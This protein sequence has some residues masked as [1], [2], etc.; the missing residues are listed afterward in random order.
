MKTPKHVILQIGA[1]V[2]LYVSIV[3]LLILIFSSINLTFPNAS[4][5]L[6]EDNSARTAI[7]TSIAMLLVFFPA[8][9]MF[10]RLSN[11]ERRKYLHGKYTLIT[12][13]FVYVTILIGVLVLLID[14]VTLINYF[15]NGEITTRFTLKVLTLLAVIGLTLTYYTLDL[16]GYFIKRMSLSLYFAV[17]TFVLVLGA[18]IY[19]YS[20]IEK[21]SEVRQ[22]R[23][24]EK[25]ITD[26][27]D[28]YWNIE[29]AYRT[30]KT[31]P[32]SLDILYTNQK[33]PTAPEGRALYTYTILDD[34]TFEL[35]AEFA[36]PS[37]K[38]ESPSKQSV[39]N[40]SSSEKDIW[41]QNNNWEHGVGV[42]CFKKTVSEVPSLV[43]LQ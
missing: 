29:D 38:Y 27:R 28:I 31:L 18:V 14:L 37:A 2:T 15:L 4:A 43:P 8:F 17:A 32:A 16:K 41:F 25:Q 19:G 1:L 22:M 24:D 34:S 9:V 35:C 39:P 12:K 10:T 3:S 26:L 33:R 20:Y 23:L 30:T 6:W 7:R 42:T 5:Y 21:P 11:Q 40:T 13:W 36:K